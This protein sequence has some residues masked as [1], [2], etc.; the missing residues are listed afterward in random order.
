MGAQ[1]TPD[2]MVFLMVQSDKIWL[3]VESFVT[4]VMKTREFDGRAERGN[5]EGQ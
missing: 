5:N 2:T 4:L 1:L 3:L